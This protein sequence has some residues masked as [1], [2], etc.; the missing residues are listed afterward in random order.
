[1]KTSPFLRP[2]TPNAGSGRSLAQQVLDVLLPT[3]RSDEVCRTTDPAS[4]KETIFIGPI[5][6]P[7]PPHLGAPAYPKLARKL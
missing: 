2:E 1:M 7:D 5:S 6:Q 3:R 4:L